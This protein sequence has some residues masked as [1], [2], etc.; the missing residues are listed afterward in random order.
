MVCEELA[1][2]PSFTAT[3]LKQKRMMVWRSIRGFTEKAT[4]FMSPR[5]SLM[6]LLTLKLV[7]R[8]STTSETP[9]DFA[10]DQQKMGV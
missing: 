9:A 1:L 6:G 5:A 8:T 4:K 3:R 2:Q 7:Q 10:C